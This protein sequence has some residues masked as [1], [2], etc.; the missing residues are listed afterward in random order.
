MTML[1]FCAKDNREIKDGPFCPHPKDFCQH[2][3]SCIIHFMEQEE[4]R[5]RKNIVID[6]N[7]MDSGDPETGSR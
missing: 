6:S 4:R 3:Q 5:E 1:Y 7:G 2:R